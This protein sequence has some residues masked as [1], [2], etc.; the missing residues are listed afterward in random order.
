MICNHCYMEYEEDD[1]VCPYCHKL[2]LEKEEYNNIEVENV[3][4]TT[5]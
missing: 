1:I 2:A 4:K 3:Y 5:E